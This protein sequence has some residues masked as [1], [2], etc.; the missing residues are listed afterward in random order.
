MQ[1]MTS[2][3]GRVGKTP[4]VLLAVV[5]GLTLG[6]VGGYSINGLLRPSSMTS[7]AVHIQ[8]NVPDSNL[9]ASVARHAGTE[10]TETRDGTNLAASV[11]RHATTERA[12][13]GAVNGLHP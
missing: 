5:A 2:R 4:F 1:A 11:G 7:P 13:T 6:G 9:A 10:R 8:T 12:E 3:S